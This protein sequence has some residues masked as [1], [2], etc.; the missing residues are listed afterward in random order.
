M[1]KT[2]SIRNYKNIQ[3]LDLAGLGQINLFTGKNNTGKSTLLEAIAIYANDA[4]LSVIGSILTD[5]G[6]IR[7]YR[8]ANGMTDNTEI[9]NAVS[10]LFTNRKG[11]NG[12]AKTIF[13]GET[14]TTLF[15]E[16]LDHL[17]GV[18]LD[19]VQFYEEKE[20]T[21]RGDIISR[22]KII[23]EGL[24][25]SLSTMD[26]EL[27]LRIRVGDSQRLIPVS[28]GRGYQV[29]RKQL[30]RSPKF[31]FIT[32]TNLS[33][34]ETGLLWDKITL[35][36]KEQYVIQGLRIIEPDIERI[37]FVGEGRHD[38]STV[39]RLKGNKDVMPL[40]SMGDGINR[41]L[42]IVLAAVNAD[43]GILLID[44]FENGLHHSVQEKLW[45][46]IFELAEQLNIQVFATTH[47]ND[48]INGFE[49]V[50]NT[51]P[52]ISG[53]LIRLERSGT[54]IK[55]VEFDKR[56]LEIATDNDIETR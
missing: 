20:E 42:S 19:L 7:N 6:E 47:S 45:K 43:E 11:T 46:I 18:Q 14:S 3:S 34:E 36:D 23:Q 40:R 54:G 13:I 52:A 48:C 41:I 25:S 53:K 35:S 31:Q 50:L 1:M 15:G 5:R 8:G 24:V 28:T 27:A 37:A 9:I 39:V 22:K 55:T 17:H 4:D 33:P 21:E 26:S 30:N 29:L 2:L 56:E 49:E 10:S 38:R 32:S 16:E 51:K 44:E 12:E